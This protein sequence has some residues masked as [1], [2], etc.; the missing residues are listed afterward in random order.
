MFQVENL[1]IALAAARFW[2]TPEQAAERAP[3]HMRQCVEE[4]L[5][6]LEGEYLVALTWVATALWLLEEGIEQ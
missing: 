2:P 3:S 1:Q 4:V 5:P 6:Q